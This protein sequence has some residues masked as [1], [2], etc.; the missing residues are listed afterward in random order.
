MQKVYITSDQM[1][2]FTCPECK[3]ARTVSITDFKNLESA[4]KVRVKCSC[5]HAYLVNIEKRRQYRLETNFPGTFTIEDDGKEVDKGPMTVVDLSRT[6]LK[7]KTN[8]EGRFNEG[9]LLKI[10]FRLDDPNR[11]LIQKEVVIRKI[12]G[13]EYGAEFTSIHPSDPSDKALGFYMLR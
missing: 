13:R 11:S 1:I 2:T 5:G 4:E 8:D 12:F 6:G 10:E 7:I 3:R 9:D